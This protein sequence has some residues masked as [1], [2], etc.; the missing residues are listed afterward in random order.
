TSVS[1]RYV[2]LKLELSK[3]GKVVN[4]EPIISTFPAFTQQI[5]SA[6]LWA[7]FSPAAVRGKSAASTCFI[8]ISFFPQIHYPT[9]VWRPSDQNSLYERLRIRLLPDTVGLL[10]EPIPAELTPE[11]FTLGSRQALFIDTVNAVVSV[12]TLG[13]A[14]V[15]R[16]GT[17]VRQLRHTVQE[18]GRRLQ[19]FPAL[20]TR[21]NRHPFTGLASFVFDG[22]TKVRVVYH[23]LAPD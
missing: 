13:L 21:G 14:A 18:I 6:I 5:Q 7:R 17:E 1:L 4:V 16:I 20:D 22:S 8:L 19:F 15:H 3:T 2:F 11:E 9:R 10:T 12:D 23:W